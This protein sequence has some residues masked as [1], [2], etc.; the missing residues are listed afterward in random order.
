MTTLQFFTALGA[1]VEYAIKLV[2]I[3]IVPE[4]RRP[5]SSTAWLL[6]ILMVPVV[7]FPLYWLLGSP[8]VK[9]RRQRVQSEATALLT[10]SLAH[11]KTV[12]GGVDPSPGLTSVLTMNRRLTGLPCVT[13]E[14]AGLYGDTDEAYAAMAAA[15]HQAEEYV[16]V[17]FYIMAWDATTDHFFGALAE[18]VQRGVSVRLLLDHI[19][20][21]RYPGWRQFTRRLTE[22]GIEWHLM[23]PIDLLRG[24]W[25]RPDLRNHR[26]LLVVDGKVA[27]I[28]SHNV[29]DPSYGSDRNVRLGR[30]WK[31]LSLRVTGQIV[32]S[33]EVVF[34]TDW[35][36]ETGQVLPPHPSHGHAGHVNGG[37]TNAMQIVPS[38]PGFPSEP[39]LRMFSTLI[40]QATRKVS[41]TSPYFVPDEYLLGAIT[42]AAFRGVRVDLFVGEEADQFIVGHAQRSYY[43]ALL[44]AGVN[45]HLYPK[46][47]VLHSKYLTI[48]DS[49][50][51]IGSS[52]LDY[53]SFALDYEITLLAFGGDLV[54]QLTANDE[55]YLA[56]SHELTIEQ[57]R[58]QP[59]HKRYLDNVCRLASAVM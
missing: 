4:N 55:E 30:A 10:Q 58:Q 56:V 28:G 33:I 14:T 52:N 6:L 11:L 3:G 47:M 36:T 35:Y 59:W 5:S 24:R 34:A 40:N 13:G 31:D 43:T 54:D 7:G 2:A 17:E 57:W 20:S 23:M 25:R 49:I 21:R 18:A 39:N 46:P 38:G 16:Y 1:V 15:V 19:G 44:E 27:F 51:M 9:G 22:A 26:K 45:I 41:I 42:S 53:R 8:Y 12:P 32:P 50:A 37:P 29:I 48:D